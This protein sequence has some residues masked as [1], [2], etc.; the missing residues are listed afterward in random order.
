MFHINYAGRKEH[1]FEDNFKTGYLSHTELG[2]IW[3]AVLTFFC[4]FS[5]PK[6]KT[7]RSM[8]DKV[9]VKKKKNG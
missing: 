6:E 8:V 9:R 1:D 3:G 5:T 2:A 7:R 4:C